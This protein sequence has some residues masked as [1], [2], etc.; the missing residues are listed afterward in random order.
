MAFKHGDT[1]NNHIQGKSLK[2]NIEGKIH[3][4][5]IQYSWKKLI[6]IRLLQEKSHT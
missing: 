6:N 1:N 4:K 3:F 2:N 5:G